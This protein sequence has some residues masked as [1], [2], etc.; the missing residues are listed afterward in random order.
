MRTLKIILIYSL[1]IIIIPF[2]IINA[3]SI[4]E[5]EILSSLE[6]KWIYTNDKIEFTV[7]LV[8]KNLKFSDWEKNYVLGNC[9]LKVDGEI[10]YDFL[11]LADRYNT[12]P[13]FDFNEII[14]LKYPD[15]LPNIILDLKDERITGSFMVYEVTKPIT[16]SVSF[17][18]ENL[19]WD[20]KNFSSKGKIDP[21]HI[22]K[23]PSTWVLQRVEE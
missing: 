5:K 11:S 6:G 13:S 4:T 9:K 16:M 20:F 21:D 8:Q 15:L 23:V 2:S 7:M 22:P 14:D 19:I 17:D 18:N 10:I 3:Q 12:K 1:L